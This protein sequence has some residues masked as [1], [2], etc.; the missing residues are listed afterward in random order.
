[1]AR[2]KLFL[3]AL[4]AAGLAQGQDRPAAA[5]IKVGFAHPLS[6][7]YSATGHRNQVAAEI[8]VADLN[9]DG[10]VLGEPVELVVADDACGVREASD[11]A[12]R[13]IQAEVDVVI[14]H[15]CSHSS[16]IAAGHYEAAGILMITSGSTHPRLTEEGRRNV[17]RLIGRDDRQG[18]LAADLLAER[19]RGRRIA[20][21]HDGSTYGAG[22]AYETR[23]RLQAN[24]VG[25]VFFARYLP[26]RG[27][28]DD[29]VDRVIDERIE[30]L[31]VGGYG[32]DA[33]AILK[34]IRARGGEVQ[35][36]GGDALVMD[37]FWAV[38]GPAGEGVVFSQRPVLGRPPEADHVLASFRSRGLGER[39]GG[40]G[41]YAAVQTWAAAVE[42]T[43]SDELKPVA[44]LLRRGRFDTVLGRVSFDDKG[45]LEGATW[46]WHVW[47]DGTYRM[48]PELPTQ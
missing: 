16:L 15:M 28:Y 48:L 2:L 27:A 46:A 20:I 12:K 44:D 32:P 13:L 35:L 43:G 34:A 29:L 8:A 17:F 30:V 39:P 14:G 40:L 19:Y 23:K 38:A 37:E 24:D 1:M 45:D 22:L 25:E 7:P 5:E 21:V 33:A 26:G 11:A 9:A 31:Y 6:G 41:V 4:I 36:I 18:Q 42:R 10:G 47:E 3:C